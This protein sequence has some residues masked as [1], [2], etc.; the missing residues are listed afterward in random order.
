MDLQRD[1]VSAELQTKRWPAHSPRDGSP[2]AVERSTTLLTIDAVSRATLPGGGWS[3]ACFADSLP[4][5][6]YFP[7]NAFTIV[8]SRRFAGLIRSCHLFRADLIGLPRRSSKCFVPRG[9]YSS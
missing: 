4:A 1:V 5:S 9:R 2:P 7:R 8:T 6:A 3:D